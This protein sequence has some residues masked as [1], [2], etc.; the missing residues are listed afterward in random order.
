[1][2]SAVRIER[3][4][5]GISTPSPDASESQNLQPAELFSRFYAS[6]LGRGKEPDAEMMTLFRRLMTEV[7]EAAPEEAAI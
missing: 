1:L 5:T 2:S 6:D 4:K 7:Q 3:T